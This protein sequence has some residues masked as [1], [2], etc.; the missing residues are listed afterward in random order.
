MKLFL[1]RAAA[2]ISLFLLLAASASSQKGSAAAS[3]PSPPLESAPKPVVQNGHATVILCLAY[4]PDGRVLATGSG[5]H[6][7]KLWDAASGKLLAT[8]TGHSDAVKSLCFSTDG[9]MLASGGDDGIARLWDVARGICRYALEDA[10]SAIALSRDGSR[11]ASGRADGL[12]RIWNTSNGKLV[13]TLGNASEYPVVTL[14]FSPDGRMLAAGGN[15]KLARVWDMDT[16]K[17]LAALAGHTNW[18]IALSFSP[19]GRTIATAGHDDTARLWEMPSGRH[20][21]T[22]AGHLGS[23]QSL[24]FS[25]S[26]RYL[27]TGSRDG[28]ARIWDSR[29]AALSVCLGRPHPLDGDLF[30]SITSI[31]FS[32]DEKAFVTACEDGTVKSWSV[33]EG[34][35]GST[36]AKP[37]GFIAALAFSPDGKTLA[38]GGLESAVKLW[39]FASGR[40]VSVFREAQSRPVLSLAFNSAGSRLAAGSMDGSAKVWDLDSGRLLSASVSSSFSALQDGVSITPSIVFVPGGSDFI[41]LGYYGEAKVLDSDTGKPRFALSGPGDAVTQAAFS[42]DGRTLATGSQSGAVV[43]LDSNTGRLRTVLKG[44][45]GPISTLSFSPDGSL[46]AA[47]S[48][49]DTAC[50]WD[51]VKGSL[52]TSLQG[53]AGHMRAVAFSPDGKWLATGG[54]THIVQ[55]W[56]P[57]TGKLHTELR[58]SSN[59]V[60]SS[61]YYSLVFNPAGRTF[62]AGGVLWSRL[63]GIRISLL[64][65]P[66]CVVFSPDGHVIYT[67]GDDGMINLWDADT[68][69]LVFSLSAHSGAVR[70]LAVSPDGRWL[71]SASID[72]TIKLWDAATGVLLATAID[73]NAGRDWLVISPEGFFD[74]TAGGWQKIVWRMGDDIFDTAEPEQYFSEFYQPG[75]LKDIFRRGRPI[76]DVL[77]ERDDPRA[78]LT[79]GEKDRRLPVVSIEAPLESSFRTVTVKLRVAEAPADRAHRTGSRVKDVR[80]FRN[81]TLVAKW[82]GEQAS[83]S[84]LT[85][86]IPIVQGSNSLFAYA[87]NKDNVKSR[88]ARAEVRGSDS[89]RRPPRAFILAVGINRYSLKRLNLEFAV[90][91][92]EDLSAILEKNLPYP[93]ESIVKRLLLDEKATRE[94]ILAAIGDLVKIIEPEDSVI[95]VYS[96]H[97]AIYG[98]TF[99]LF[100]HDLGRREDASLKDLC[101]H[102]VSDKDLQEILTGREGRGGLRARHIALIIDACHSGQVLEADEWRVGPMN[103]RGLAQLAWEKGMEILTASQSDQFAME[104]KSLGH[105]LLTYALLEGF[106]GAPRNEGRLLGSAWLDFAAFEVPRLPESPK[107]RGIVPPFVKTVRTAGSSPESRRVYFQIPRVFHPRMDAD[108]GEWIVSGKPGEDTT[109]RQVRRP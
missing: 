49:D 38:A 99:Y 85:C 36:L 91:D 94:E 97:G 21:A 5:D 47:G 109:G 93:A 23:V 17:L 8:L 88:D 101:A 63:A 7:I 98:K 19:D 57:R 66:N 82:E 83:G 22:L 32:P 28:T 84:S 95:V 105:G 77:R 33:P 92:V 100:P 31:A 104:M 102:G 9:S 61:G 108:A 52:L 4:S 24:T 76:R 89:L 103:S 26:G 51:T 106:S 42:P 44:H 59:V 53:R 16:G 50:V 27:A 29:S 74:G 68:G 79:I 86:E 15:D 75:L 58:E 56:E 34:T 48:Y 20:L 78:S 107:T 87:F 39:D 96:G 70:S 71:A 6:T 3:G 69:R 80:L 10:G 43:L 67:G 18:I 62:A 81:G 13:G 30:D 73:F 12:V 40:E 25:P 37:G 72:T 60:W 64:E 54:F 14:A 41:A 55:V 11:L 35:L 65:E 45:T 46:L 1:N 2:L 90:K